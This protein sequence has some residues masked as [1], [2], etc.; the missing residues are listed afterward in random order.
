MSCSGKSHDKGFISHWV[1]MLARNMIWE[2]NFILVFCRMGGGLMKITVQEPRPLD[3][4][5]PL[6]EIWCET[7]NRSSM[8]SM[9]LRAPPLLICLLPPSYPSCLWEIKS[10]ILY[11]WNQRPDRLKC[12]QMEPKSLARSIKTTTKKSFK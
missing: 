4:K 6:R 3:K 5:C 11:H 9:K 1:P 12:W 2:I 7:Q 10:C 8:K